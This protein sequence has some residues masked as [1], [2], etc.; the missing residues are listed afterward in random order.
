M[1]ARGRIGAFAVVLALLLS[2]C[3]GGD[4][5]DDGDDRD[6][7]AVRAAIEAFETRVEAEGYVVDESADDE[8]EDLEFTSDDCR[9]LEDAFPDGGELPGQT[10]SVDSESFTRGELAPGGGTEQTLEASAGT[11]EDPGDLVEMF[12]LLRDDRVVPC[13]QEALQRSFAE[14]PELQGVE[15]GEVR[16]EVADLGGIGDDAVSL[17]VGTTMA[18]GGLSFPIAMDFSLARKGRAAVMVGAAT[19]GGT[20]IG[21]P[22]TDL[23]R[24]LLGDI[25]LG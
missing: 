25:R 8:D 7:A 15:L 24:S 22:V 16:V 6:E 2:A 12:E 17:R 21:A 1:S 4:D 18:M 23:A 20:D 5:G 10:A 19:I 11:A 3:G 9:E 14:D 13:V